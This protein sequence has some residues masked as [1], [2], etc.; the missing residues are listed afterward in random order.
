MSG[1]AFLTAEE[2]LRHRDATLAASSTTATMLAAAP[3]PSIVLYVYVA[4]SQDEGAGRK[5]PVERVYSSAS[6]EST[7][8]MIERIR[9]QSR[10]V[11]LSW[12]TSSH[13]PPPRL[14]STP[15]I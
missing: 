11:R 14:I 15:F 6:L 5:W 10:T 13:T 2:Y 12:P 9:L 4:G 8:K 7:L 3:S 1:L